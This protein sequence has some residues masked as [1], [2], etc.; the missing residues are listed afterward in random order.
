[1]KDEDFLHAIVEDI[2]ND[3]PR[4]V[5]A[6]W[7]EE[8]GD[9]LQIERAN[10]IRDQIELAKLDAADPRYPVLPHRWQVP[11]NSPVGHSIGPSELVEGR[12]LESNLVS[13]VTL[14]P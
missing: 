14:P 7:L 6:D 8:Q 5:Y 9:E 2:D 4:L 12:A 1:M 10:F 3:A 13:G 11:T